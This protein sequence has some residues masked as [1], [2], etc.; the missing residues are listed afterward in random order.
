MENKFPIA[1]I[2][3]SIQGEG[4]YTGTP[5][6]F[7]R[8]G[9]CNLACVWCDTPYAWK[10]GFETYKNWPI[11]KVI[12]TIQKLITKRTETLTIKKNASRS[13]LQNAHNLHLAITGGEP[14]LH[15]NF[16]AEIRQNFPNAF[17]EVETNGTIPAV[18]APNTVN[19]FNISPKLSNSKNKW[20][21]LNLRPHDHN[22]H[23]RDR[24]HKTNHIYKFVIQKKSD[25]AEI[26][27]FIKKEKLPRKKI[28]LMPE[29]VTPK[30][31]EQKAKW[32]IP[33]CKEKKFHYST[34]LHILKKMR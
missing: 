31:I 28:Y 14:M 6:I 4:M 21:K 18:F 3:A 29:G 19:Q 32:L 23:I 2:F 30:K 16:I 5:A 12:K 13:A 11:E 22:P 10:K 33:L 20:Y 15:Q 27:K 25:I 17:I 9:K 8:T 1:E 7:I 24:S 26:E 34:R